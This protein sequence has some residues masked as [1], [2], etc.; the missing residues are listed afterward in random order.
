M[1]YGKHDKGTP[2]PETLEKHYKEQIKLLEEKVRKTEGKLSE[3]LNEIERLSFHIQTDEKHILELEH[4]LV[5]QTL[6]AA[7]RK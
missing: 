6:L 2:I 5:Q 4:A 3:A 1:E 7:A